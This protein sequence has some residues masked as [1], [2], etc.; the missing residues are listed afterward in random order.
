MFLT[1]IKLIIHEGLGVPKYDLTKI[2]IPKQPTVLCVNHI[3]PDIKKYGNRRY[4]LLLLEP[5]VIFS[6]K[7][8][9][10]HNHRNFYAILTFQEEILSSCPNAVPFLFGTTWIPR[11]I[12]MSPIITN[13]EFK[14]SS[15]TG[16]PYKQISKR[17]ITTPGWTLR[18][19]LYKRQ[20][21]ITIPSVF[22]RSSHNAIPPIGNNP[23]LTESKIPLFDTFQFSIVIENSRQKHYFTEKLCDCLLMRTIPIYYGCPN[24]SSYF[25]TR[26]WILLE[27]D[28]PT[29][30]I[31][32]IN[33]LTESHYD[34]YRP[35]IEWNANRCLV[36]ADI[37]TNINRALSQVPGY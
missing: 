8:Y 14:V 27:S 5:D 20:M 1:S 34:L 17:T 36:Y 11:E 31:E 30:C 29:E 16:A 19:S 22:F 9:V 13:K 32:K 21:E 15:L 23:L 6:V 28:D 25:D 7:Q 4:I 24:I 26:G 35:I 37:Y 12:Y 33:S 10:I 2:K 3:V 18:Y